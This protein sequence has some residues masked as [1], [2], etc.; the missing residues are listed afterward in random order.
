MAGPPTS[1]GAGAQT[2]AAAAATG[3]A[4]IGSVNFAP[5]L[6]VQQH[7]G[8]DGAALAY[9]LEQRMRREFNSMIEEMALETGS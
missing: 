3:A 1:I 2:G 8:Q 5:V 7:P 4:G 6:N 9:D